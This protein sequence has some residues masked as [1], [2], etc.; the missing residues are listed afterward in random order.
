MCKPVC[1]HSLWSSLR[2]M[3]NFS[4]LLFSESALSNKERLLFPQEHLSMITEDE[5][6]EKGPCSKG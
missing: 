4:W 2:E 1:M 6:G 3:F 5:V